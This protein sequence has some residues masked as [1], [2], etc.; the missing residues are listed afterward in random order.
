M[1]KCKIYIAT[2]GM[3]KLL[4]SQF[5]SLIKDS[6]FRK[7][8]KA[9]LGVVIRK[10]YVLLTRISRMKSCMLFQVVI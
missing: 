8:L 3:D 4:I 9:K 10:Y 7:Y 5:D 2:K 6:S 1:A